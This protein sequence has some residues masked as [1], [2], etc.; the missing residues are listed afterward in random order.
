MVRAQRG[1][2]RESSSPESTD[3]DS[4]ESRAK[5]LVDVVLRPLIHADGG[6]IELVS[7][8]A[9]RLVVRLTGTCAGCPGRPYTLHGVIERAAR[10]ALNAAIRV[11]LAPD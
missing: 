2:A 5:H 7:T 1:G 9:E 4:L 3:S 6:E 11:E 10:K 8:S